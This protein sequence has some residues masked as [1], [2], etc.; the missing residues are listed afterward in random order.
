MRKPPEHLLT[1]TPPRRHRPEPAAALTRSGEAEQTL[2]VK[3]GNLRHTETS[4]TFLADLAAR[5]FRDVRETDVWFPLL[6]RQPSSG[7][8][9]R[10][11]AT[12]H[13]EGTPTE[14]QHRGFTPKQEALQN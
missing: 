5:L 9:C 3:H 7:G 12:A 1:S 4:K 11:G 6:G 14:S 8:R 2:E 13:N 10:P